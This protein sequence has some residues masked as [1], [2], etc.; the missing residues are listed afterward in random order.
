VRVRPEVSDLLFYH[1]LATGLAAPGLAP[2]RHFQDGISTEKRYQGS[3]DVNQTA[4]VFITASALSTAKGN[5]LELASK[6][7]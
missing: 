7:A 5:P 1:L 3:L 4:P 6:A 2:Q